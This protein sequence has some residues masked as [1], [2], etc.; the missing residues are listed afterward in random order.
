M[1]PPSICNTHLHFCSLVW[2]FETCYEGLYDNEKEHIFFSLISSS[3]PNYSP[4]V[5]QVSLFH[6]VL[7]P[8]KWEHSQWTP[9]LPPSSF[10]ISYSCGMQTV[11]QSSSSTP[12][13]LM[14]HSSLTKGVCSAS[15]LQCC[16]M[17]CSFKID[18]NSVVGVLGILERYW[19][20]LFVW[21]IKKR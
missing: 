5:L 15:L 19:Q 17:F 6:F 21:S 18:S 12:D 3:S 1:T 10:Y 14:D 8:T 7:C 9:R 13:K 16:P 11:A 2:V 4:R 20:N